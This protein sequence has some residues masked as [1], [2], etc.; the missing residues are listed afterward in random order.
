MGCLSFESLICKVKSPFLCLQILL[1]LSYHLFPTFFTGSWRKKSRFP[2]EASRRNTIYPGSGARD[3]ELGTFSYF[4]PHKR[5][6][7]PQIF[8]RVR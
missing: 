6:L 2:E 8:L 4:E 5:N 7:N 1:F 3:K